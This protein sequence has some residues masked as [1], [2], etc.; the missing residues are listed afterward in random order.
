MLPE[1]KG[2]VDPLIHPTTIAYNGALSA[3]S[4]FR[5]GRSP[6]DKRI[7]EDE[8]TKDTIWWGNV[9]MKISPKGY[10]RNRKRTTDFINIRPYVFVIDGYAGWEKDT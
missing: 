9:N 5:T 3:S 7:V 4:G 8:I 2:S 1:L 6:T 10:A